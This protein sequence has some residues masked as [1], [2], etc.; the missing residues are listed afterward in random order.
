M[1][2]VASEFYNF[3]QLTRLNPALLDEVNGGLS[4][5]LEAR[6]GK[7][8]PG[9]DAGTFFHVFGGEAAGESVRVIDALVSLRDFLRK[10]GDALAGFALFVERYRET[11]PRDSVLRDLKECLLRIED[12]DQLTAG[13]A[14]AELF[15][16]MASLEPRGRFF[17]VLD[18][19][20]RPGLGIGGVKDFCVRERA[21]KELVPL[22]ASRLDCE[23]SPDI[24]LV[25]G[26]WASGVSFQVNA[27]IRSLV[28]EEAILPVFPLS[29]GDSFHVPFVNSI[30]LARLGDVSEHLT[31]VERRLLAEK[32]DV[33]GFFAEGP[34]RSRVP[35]FPEREIFT[36]F[37]LMVAAFRRKCEDLLSP[38]VV[39]C[40]DFHVH[41]PEARGVLAAVFAECLPRFGANLVCTSA[42]PFLGY[43]F[44]NFPVVRRPLPGMERGEIEEITEAAGGTEAEA[45]RNAAVSKGC[46]LNLYHALQASS[47]EG[48]PT[49]ALVRKQEPEFRDALYV[50]SSAGTILSAVRLGDF[51]EEI[52]VP[53][54]KTLEILDRCKEFGL[55]RDEG[56]PAALLPGGWGRLLPDPTPR[57]GLIDEKLPAFLFRL[58][59][60]GAVDAEEALYRFFLERGQSR[61]ALDVLRLLYA[62]RIDS[63]DYTEARKLLYG[64]LP[65]RESEGEERTVTEWRDALVLSGRLRLA[66]AEGDGPTSAAL[67]ARLESYEFTLPLENPSWGECLLQQARYLA[68]TLDFK[69]AL[70]FSKKAAIH[71][72]DR[73]GSAGAVRANVE[74]GLVMLAQENLESALDYFRIAHSA[75]A[76]EGLLFD[77]VRSGF[78][79]AVIHFLQGNYSRVI[80]GCD[81]LVRLADAVYSR[82]WKILLGFLKGRALFE[83]GEYY[84][85]E[86][87]FFGLLAECEAL[88]YR[89]PVPVLR[90]WAGRSLL[91][92]GR[93]EEGTAVLDGIERSREALYFRAE[94]NAFAGNPEAAVKILADLLAEPPETDC[95]RGDGFAWTDG[96]SFAE[97]LLVGRR[98]GDTVLVRQTKALKSL[99]TAA[100]GG[101]RQA[102]EEMHRFIKED[103]YSEHDP[104]NRLYFYWYSRILP[105]TK[106]RNYEDRLTILGLAV[107]YLNQRAGR[108]DEPAHKASFAS[109]NRWN[110]MLLEEA[111]ELNLV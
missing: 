43:E 73:E 55:I 75:A 77:R 60:K 14:A 32:R 105:R 71:L 17:R 90:A 95:F 22:I 80:E 57:R 109:K 106:D 8:V 44:R 11:D 37:S 21:V 58:W 5:L 42:L 20:A 30:R 34:R 85:S 101:F 96:F 84:G 18:K 12:E 83:L 97:N 89:P 65:G 62:E 9:G 38:A 51:L 54:E 7:R 49:L 99:Q 35:D 61:Y 70:D 59:K 76:N 94:G 78:F 86:S 27:A 64:D 23:G 82:R 87:V 46:I 4:A 107:K 40:E 1:L 69:R 33:L 93:T 63:G 79:E 41:S 15:S 19:T 47:F 26:P 52:D 91:Y 110:R 56:R 31:S 100:S 72:Q 74:I 2:Y 3:K 45:E 68:S 88:R 98:G 104:Y 6:G 39:V 36:V 53:R 111:R 92:G 50:L 28:D 67:F 103:A 10:R 48:D 66:M 108:I 102:V 16:G 29:R 24:L 81:A 25:H 13:S